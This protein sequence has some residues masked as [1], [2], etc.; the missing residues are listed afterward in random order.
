[1]SAAS[2]LK[3]SIGSQDLSYMASGQHGEVYKIDGTQ[4]AV[5]ISKSSDNFHEVEKQI[6]ERL[7][8]HQDLLRYYNGIEV[9]FPDGNQKGLVFEFHHRGKLADNLYSEGKGEIPENL[10]HRYV[11]GRAQN[12]RQETY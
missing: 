6:Y 8:T 1:M 10:R 2:S 5:K 3:R 11:H 12:G 9:S 4:F 7:G